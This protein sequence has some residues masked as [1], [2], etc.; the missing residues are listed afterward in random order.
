MSYSAGT[1]WLQ[2]IPSF[3][4]I[5]RELARDV[6]RLAQQI[7]RGLGRAIP[8]A[9][10]RGV[11]EGSRS[12]DR[13]A[14]RTG[15]RAGGR[16]GD[17][18]SEQMHRRI[19]SSLR[20]LPENDVEIGVAR[21]A[22]DQEMKE[23]RGEL[24]H[25]RDQHINLEID[26]DEAIRRLNN[27]RDR[28]RELE[29]GTNDRAS[30]VNLRAAGADLDA[31]EA[32]VR[33][34]R[35]S[36]AEAG[37]NFGG[38]F[39]RTAREHLAAL[40]T[41]LPDIP[42]E[43]DPTRFNI[44]MQNIR[45]D[46]GRLRD[47]RIGIDGDAT[48]FFNR[49]RA[50]EARIARLR[51]QDVSIPVNFDLD[52]ASAT[53]RQFMER[54]APDM[55]R[56]GGER[57]SGRFADEVNNRIGRALRALPAIEIDADATPA[58]QEIARIRTELMSI[59]DL[60][61]RGEL[62]AGQVMARL[63]VLQ[64]RLRQMSGE[65]VDIQVR[66][67]SAAAVAELLAIAALM[68][69]L[70]GQ[71]ANLGRSAS[72][73]IGRLGA[74]IALALSLG[75]IV[76]PAAAAAAVAIGGI[77]TA[78]AGAAAG[79][80]VLILGFSG[81]VQGVTALHK[82]QQDANKSAKS[83]LASQNQISNAVDGVANAERSLANTR[84][85]VS[86]AGLR[87]AKAVRDAQEQVTEAVKNRR[88]AELD[89]IDAIK[90]AR[91]LDEDRA[92]SLKENALAQRQ[93]TL[94]IADAKKEL[95]AVLSNPKATEAERE[96]ARITY[97]ERIAQMERLKLEGGR[98]QEEQAEASAKGVMGSKQVVAAQERV[99]DS[100]KAVRDAEE[101]VSEAR[102]A[103]AEQARQGAFQIAQ[104]QQ[105]VIAAQRSAEQA[106]VSAGVAGGEALD[107]LKDAFASLSPEAQRFI[108]YL[109]SMKDGAIALRQAA[110]RGM[111]PGFQEALREIQPMLPGIEQF[112]FKIGET[113]GWVAVQTVS[114]FQNPVWRQFFGYISDTA[115]PALRGLWTATELFARGLASLI[116][117]LSPF[118]RSM[119]KGLIEMAQTFA[120]WADK[121][122][123]SSGYVKFID[124]IRDNGPAVVDF[125]KELGTFVKHFVIAAAPIGAVVLRA[126]D[127]LFSVINGI[128]L[129]IL[130]AIITLIGLLSIAILANAAATRSMGLAH[131]LSNSTAALWNRTMAAGTTIAAAYTTS[132]GAA[133]ASTTRLGTTMVVARGAAVA[134]GTALRG[135]YMMLGGPWGIAIIAATLLVSKMFSAMSEASNKAKELRAGWEQYG[136]ALKDGVTVQSQQAAQ[137]ILKQN[138]G[139]R[140]LLGT[141]REVGITQRNLVNGLN[142][143]AEA[144]A[145]V[146]K[147]I[148][149]EIERLGKLNSVPAYQN[150]QTAEE[151]MAN[152]ERIRKLKEL[153]EQFEAVSQAEQ[154]ASIAA[155]YLDAAHDEAFDGVERLKKALGDAPATASQFS[156]AIGVLGSFA[157]ET[158][159]KFVGL[160]QVADK[161]GQSNLSASEKTELFNKILKTLGD[162]A[163]ASGPTFDALAGTFSAIATSAISARDKSDL[164]TQAIDQMYGAAI[165]QT[166]A[167]DTLARTQLELTRQLK[168]NQFG[169]DLTTAA[170]TGHTQEV[171]ANR[172]AL[173]AA[174][175]ALRD[176]YVQDLANGESEAVARQ[177]HE[178]STKALLD[179]LPVT[180]SNSAA[181]EELNR[182]Y[183]SIP[184]VKKTD[185]STPGLDQAI[186]DLVTAHAVQIGLTMKP[187]WDRNQISQEV[188]YLLKTING[189]AG[190]IAMYKATGG[191]IEGYSPHRT[192][193]NIGVWA[194]AGEYMHSVPAVDYY[195]EEFM[196]AVNQRRFPRQLA[197][198][199]ATGGLIGQYGN[200]ADKRKWPVDIPSPI[201]INIADY[202][203]RYDEEVQ[204][205]YAGLG[206]SLGDVGPGPGFP[207][208]PRNPGAQRG[209]SGVWRSIVNLIRSTGP[210][211]GVFG[212]AYRPGD[213]LWHGSGRAVD[214]LGFQQDALATFLASKS[215]LELIHRT[216]RRD[217]AFTRGRNMGSF[218]NALM[219]AHRNHIHIAMDDGGYL[220]P[221][222]NP[223]IWNG[224]GTVEPVLNPTQW[225]TMRRHVD[226]ESQRPAG[227]PRQ[228]NFQFANTTLTPGKLRAMQDRDD[229]LS[230]RGR[231]R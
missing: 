46:I 69:T 229:V 28:M 192:A 202:W 63:A 60:H 140:D 108:R 94:D 161:V 209:D 117:A 19:R 141:A 189:K 45:R 179:Q 26:D 204:A 123:S 29:R 225:D 62:D 115:G 38:A 213:P 164:L 91:R 44:V 105:A 114:A 170:A 224:T 226:L 6:D 195:G 13:E 56:L 95:D 160:A 154:D 89:L 134:T 228:Y 155:K 8:D 31:F 143:D 104:A 151:I 129:P 61:I 37:G 206:S 153:R 64:A 101:R 33:E 162:S 219:Q 136:Q 216:S 147:S 205:Y 165:K 11:D 121:L 130:S 79:L 183:G 193:D 85:N 132:T 90:Q 39:G 52:R 118:N 9:M 194:T 5:D 41:S 126:F 106:Y 73:S 82:Y 96:Q 152:T 210:L 84:E 187:L 208:W 167:A 180:Q 102:A 223:P 15:R 198:G 146:I 227:I 221:G 36:G 97:E 148:D 24:E 207:P 197:H 201:K 110:E 74:I 215:P 16:Y 200:H 112:I 131:A 107:N 21:N 83:L 127:A 199:Y 217:Y 76:V 139:L 159:G 51:R 50:I 182:D 158:G 218:N 172:E 18:F 88:R 80:G 25:V 125:F 47:F 2:V 171:L 133:A 185:V 23:I 32:L 35:R 156:D 20:A 58:R 71:V 124:Y 144:R 10:R 48:E 113:L 211:S 212:N 43:A 142:G 66:V 111:L 109:Y 184:P 135:M 178:E 100:Q 1:A 72:G 145:N 81:V 87:A 86:Q 169:F 75:T 34:A 166:E 40:S 137:Q 92:I 54:V 177:R 120:T 174:L 157:S 53:L 231:A 57:T 27:V 99:L 188:D 168:D 196:D 230:R 190:S 49:L 67:D 220:Q 77:A 149:D 203:K 17:A 150:T 119:G 4:H 98:L 173:K 163:S 12:M 181:V 176:K 42:I 22:F 70:D 175:Q 78:A 191:P 55:G 14:D 214:W 7:D 186:I 93:N 122:S 59:R 138:K 116:F 30:V 65:D 222:W 128:P 68:N 103:Q 3:R